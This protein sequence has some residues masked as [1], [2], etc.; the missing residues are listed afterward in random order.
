MIVFGVQRFQKLYYRK[1]PDINVEN[2]SNYF[3]ADEELN[4][5][6]LGFKIA[7]GVM[8]YKDRIPLLDPEIME[9]NVF[10]EVRAN[11]ELVE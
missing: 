2:I 3:K 10:L 7:F 9:W 4:L 11:L 6:D 8:N 5:S 1:G